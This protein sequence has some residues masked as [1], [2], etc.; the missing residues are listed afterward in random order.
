M[1]NY[2]QEGTHAVPFVSLDKDKHLLIF[3]GES[4]PEDVR[5]VFVPILKWMEDYES[6]IHYIYQTWNKVVDLKVEFKMEYFNSSSA[7]FIFDIML[8]LK[9]LMTSGQVKLDISWKYD[10]YDLDMED[11]G[12]EFEEMLEID[13]EFM[14]IVE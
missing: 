6:L 12:K 5:G 1:E 3:G 4:R 14:E 7:K 2:L 9:S 13:F 8:K 10:Q 11:A